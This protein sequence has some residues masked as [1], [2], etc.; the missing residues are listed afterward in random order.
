MYVCICQG[1]TE[2]DIEQAMSNGAD[3]LSQLQEELQVARCC[4]SCAETVESM[5][6]RLEPAGGACLEPA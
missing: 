1:V 6:A 5:L 3:S 2:R 4:G